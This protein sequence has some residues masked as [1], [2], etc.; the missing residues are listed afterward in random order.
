MNNFL[1]KLFQ[2]QSRCNRAE[3]IHID[4]KPYMSIGKNPSNYNLLPSTV[5]KEL[6]HKN[7]HFRFWKFSNLF[8]VICKNETIFIDLND[9][10][11]IE[12]FYL[13]PAKAK[14]YIGL[15]AFPTQSSVTNGVEL[16]YT[17]PYSEEALQGF[18]QLAK[19]VSNFIDKPIE[20]VDYGADC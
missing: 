10:Q 2:M 5:K 4:K 3:I 1:R 13:T 14:G 12:L 9:F 17:A 11:K 6:K 15:V 8:G 18:K 7:R 20:V 19:K 16:C